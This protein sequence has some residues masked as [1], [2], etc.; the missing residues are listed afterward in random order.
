MKSPLL[1][2][3]VAAAL[4]A[5]TAAE[6]P[7]AQSSDDQFASQLNLIRDG[8]TVG[9]GRLKA[10]PR[11]V[12]ATQETGPNDPLL[13]AQKPLIDLIKK[14]QPSVVFLVMSGGE[15]G[16]GKK[17]G[18]GI[19]T[20]FFTDAMKELG[21]P[22][23]ITTNAHCVEKLAVGAEIQVGSGRRSRVLSTSSTKAMSLAMRLTP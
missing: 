18:G 11:F 13:L 6:S 21:R 7:A 8:F 10:L 20:G 3:A 17:P 23:V 12:P 1:S 5:G 4:A 16:N 22:S 14:V 15:A 19:C 9:S 2:F